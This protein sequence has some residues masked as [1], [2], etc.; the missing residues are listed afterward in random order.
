MCCDDVY[1][2]TPHNSALA[3]C[4]MKV[5]ISIVLEDDPYSSTSCE[6]FGVSAACEDEIVGFGALS[7][8]VVDAV[9]V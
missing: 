7:I 5:L 3:G 6:V 9:G 1:R 2:V 8:I 4:D